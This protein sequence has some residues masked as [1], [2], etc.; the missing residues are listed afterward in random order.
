MESKIYFNA[1]INNNQDI[2]L[3]T[4]GK[5]LRLTS[6]PAND[7]WPVISPDGTKMVFQSNRSGNYNLYLLDLKTNQ[8]RQL[9]FDS[10][11]KLSPSFHPNGETVVFDLEIKPNTF[12]SHKLS[13]SSG[14]IVPLFPESPYNQ[15]IV[16][17]YHPDGQRIFFTAKVF[18]GWALALYNEPAKEYKKLTKRGNCRPKVS[19]DGKLVAYVSFEDDGLGDV[20]TITPD[21]KNRINRT[22]NRS[23]HYDYY[24]CFSPDSKWIVFSSSPREKGKQGYQLY[25]LNLQSGETR[26]ILKVDANCQFPF[27]SR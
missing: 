14:K 8:L 11:N 12:S 27:W 23:H 19:P 6:D 1:P 20:C 7:E 16:P 2:Y 22:K 15:N 13:L 24:P 5:L 9:T 26:Q 18:L 4:A 25:I 3:L 21:G 17:F 10:R